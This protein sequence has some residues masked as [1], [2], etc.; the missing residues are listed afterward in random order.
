MHVVQRRPHRGGAGRA[1]PAPAPTMQLAPISRPGSIFR[2]TRGEQAR[3]VRR[4]VGGRVDDRRPARHPG[5]VPALRRVQRLRIPGRP[6]AADHRP[7]HAAH[8]RALARRARRR[9]RRLTLPSSPAMPELPEVETIRRHLAPARRGAGA[10]RARGPRRALVPAAGR[11]EVA[12]AV[13]GR[14]VEALAPAREVPDLGAR[15]RRPPDA[16]PA[17]DRHAAARPAG[18][19]ARTRACAS[20]STTGGELIFDDPRR[21]GTGE[22][23]LGGDGARRVLRRAARRRAV[24]RRSSRA[25]TSTR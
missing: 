16:P 1:P 10:D 6:G 22:L 12:A 23:A 9:D 14:R 11:R 20:R 25:R 24:R 5:A 21:F 13:R 18:A 17:H 19:A 3:G 7:R 2:L 8:A 4:R 15:G